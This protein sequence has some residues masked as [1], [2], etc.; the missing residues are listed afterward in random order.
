[1]AQASCQVWCMVLRSI[2]CPDWELP[3]QWIWQPVWAL[4][5][6]SDYLTV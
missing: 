5:S 4:V 1:M 2:L 6:V 3:V